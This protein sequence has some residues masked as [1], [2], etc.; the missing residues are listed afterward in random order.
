VVAVSIIARPLNADVRHV[1]TMVARSP[2]HLR[3]RLFEVFPRFRQYWEDDENPHVD[4]GTFTYH[5]LMLLFTEF[6]GAELTELS[7]QQVKHLGGLVNEAIAQ[8]GALENAISTCFLEHLHQIDPYK[9]LM[10]F[11]SAD[12]KER[13]HA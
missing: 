10:P 12:A 11:L 6:F 9:T 3:D 7:E 8:P 4:S 2:E 1:T 5:G 13:S